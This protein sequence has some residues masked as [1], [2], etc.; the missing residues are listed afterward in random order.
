MR[1]EVLKPHGRNLPAAR[2]GLDDWSWEGK[3]ENDDFGLCGPTFAHCILQY[4]PIAKKK[5]ENRADVMS[6]C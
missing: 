3:R 2:R 4:R 6:R 1:L 5:L